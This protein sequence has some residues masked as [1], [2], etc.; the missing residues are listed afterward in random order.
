MGIYSGSIYRFVESKEAL[1]AEIINGYHARLSDADDA[2]MASS[3]S[4]VEKLDAL[5]WVHI[6]SLHQFW[7][8]FQIQLA[9]LREVQPEARSVRMS[10][11][12]RAR[13]VVALVKDG[14]RTGALKPSQLVDSNLPADVFALSVRNLTWLPASIVHEHG[15]RVALA[16]CRETILRG[17]T[18]P[19]FRRA[20]VDE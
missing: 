10:N 9:W 18:Q 20:V 15:P 19:E 6:R 14:L 8:E 2:V 7:E 4:I 11:D 5:C 3:S 17:A 12:E 13:S 1:L 16:L